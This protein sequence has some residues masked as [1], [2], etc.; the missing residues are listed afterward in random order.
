MERL[1]KAQ[2]LISLGQKDKFEQEIGQKILQCNPNHPLILHIL[3][4]ICKMDE[5]GKGSGPAKQEKL[6]F[7]IFTIYQNALLASGY[8]LQGK[9]LYEFT[10][11]IYTYLYK[12]K[13]KLNN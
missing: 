1:A 3:D 9:E 5:K 7:K 11:K 4:G 8:S 10:G 2:A 13:F 6:H 12:G